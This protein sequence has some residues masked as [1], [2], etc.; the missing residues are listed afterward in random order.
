M[1][2]TNMR[3]PENDEGGLYE[4]RIHGHL[5]DRWT[6]WFEGLTITLEKNGDTLISGWV[7]DQAALFGLLRKVRDTGMLLVSINCISAGRADHYDDK[8]SSR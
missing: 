2:K 4:I 6:V 8:S 3:K 5:G 7:T 1:K